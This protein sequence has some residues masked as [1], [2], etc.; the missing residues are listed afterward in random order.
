MRWSW[1][2]SPEPVT[3]VGGPLAG[4]VRTEELSPSGL[5][6]WGD[7]FQSYYGPA[8]WDDES[9]RWLRQ[10]TATEPITSAPVLSGR[11]TATVLATDGP[12]WPA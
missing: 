8:R 12:G 1:S 10:C 7:G 3:Y 5:V 6:V 2:T 11:T 4:E 9:F